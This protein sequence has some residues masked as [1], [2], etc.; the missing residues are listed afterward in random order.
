[1]APT[2][3]ATPEAGRSLDTTG[4]SPDEAAEDALGIGFND[5]IGIQRRLML[6]GFD[7]RGVD[8]SFG[9]GTR[10]AIGAW[11]RGRTF[12]PTGFFNA[13]TYPALLSQTEAQYA[14][15]LQAQ[16]ARVQTAAPT[17]T[18]QPQPAAQQPTTTAQ[19]APSPSVTPRDVINGAGAVR[20]M[21]RIF[22]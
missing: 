1:M 9:P 2:N 17:P 5:K 13:Q 11:Q 20:D 12:A 4:R 22:R 10:N 8:G 21:I 14:Q 6:L 19:P 7:P 3:T 16:R 15:W 18:Y